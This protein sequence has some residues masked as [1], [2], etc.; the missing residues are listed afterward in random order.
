MCIFSPYA[1][2]QTEVAV[3]HKA[4]RFKVVLDGHDADKRA[5]GF[6]GSDLHVLGHAGHD[7]RFKECS[8]QIMRFAARQD[9]AATSDDVVHVILHFGHGIA[10]AVMGGWD[11]DCTGASVGSILGVMKGTA[12]IPP[13][14]VEPLNNTISVDAGLTL[15][16]AQ[17]AAVRHRDAHDVRLALPH[18]AE[19]TPAPAEP[20]IRIPMPDKLLDEHA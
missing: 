6:F 3:I 16:E 7:R 13:S 14:W 18:L 9:C 4:H 17:H 19:E 8:T 15:E 5:K 10:V 20:L 12:G 11:T 2:G 1:G